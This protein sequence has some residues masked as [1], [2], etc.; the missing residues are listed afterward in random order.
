MRTTILAA[1]ASLCW[2]VVS[3]HQPAFSQIANPAG[4]PR[5]AARIEG[6]TL[7]RVSGVPL[8][9]VSL[10]LQPVDHAAATRT[11]ISDP[12]GRFLFDNVELGAYRL[13][14]ERQGFLRQDF[15]ALQPST[16][17]TPISVTE[18]V[19]KIVFQLLP[20]SA[21]TG[22]VL[23]DEGEPAPYV[24]VVLLRQVGF[25]NTRHLIKLDATSTNDVGEFRIAG[26]EPGPYFLAANGRDAADAAVSGTGDPVENFVTSF[27]PGTT[28]IAAA[29]PVRVDPGQDVSGAFIR[30]QK[31][32]VV[33][34]GGTVISNS[35]R[36]RRQ[37]VEIVLV[38]QGGLLGLSHLAA[39]TGDDGSFE[40]GG[41]EVGSYEL[42]AIRTLGNVRVV[43]RVSAE[44]T[45]TRR[46]VVVPLNEGVPLTGSVHFD[47]PPPAT[48]RWP[49]IVL[50]PVEGTPVVPMSA[51][52]DANGQFHFEGISPGEYRVNFVSLPDGVCVQAMRFAGRDVLGES[53]DLTHVASRAVLE[54]TLGGRA[55]VIQGVVLNERTPAPGTVLLVPDPVRP[56]A[57]FLYQKST[58]DFLGRF[59]FGGI[60]PGRYA[61]FAWPDDTDLTDY[62]EPEFV[63]PFE[64]V[65]RRVDI[66][67]STPQTVELQLIHTER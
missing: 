24:D 59:H 39:T 22:Q 60:T 7:N 4:L 29:L 3:A 41:V 51:P 26:L 56:N 9:R 23:D 48:G 52:T 44:L 40:I 53:I 46:D 32:R 10:F 54:V 12:D 28:A 42:F 62:L 25:G 67:N 6:H 38:P 15:G 43:G 18:P 49:T 19:T 50:Q 17:G 13:S 47:G 20:Q 2:P 57:P 35:P 45:S 33:T 31:G 27:Y 11:T 30:L 66:T 61:L 63:K 14:A 65:A 34:L 37:G 8:R 1:V 58:T 64:R 16:R 55:G 21:I 5:A 36:I